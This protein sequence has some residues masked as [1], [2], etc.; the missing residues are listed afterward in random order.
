MYF[1][2]RG[3]FPLCFKYVTRG[4]LWHLPSTLIIKKYITGKRGLSQRQLTGKKL[5]K[6]SLPFFWLI[7]G[8]AYQVIPTSLFKYSLYFILKTF[9]YNSY[10]I[11]IYMVS[12]FNTMIYA[13]NYTICTLA[14]IL[15]TCVFLF[16]NYI[17][18]SAFFSFTYNFYQINTYVQINGVFKINTTQYTVWSHVAFIFYSSRT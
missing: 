8:D 10:F 1:K 14:N 3:I 16:K 13:Q 2:T 15:L 17:E 11:N 9:A 6:T 7:T 5:T 18:K 12:I 4:T